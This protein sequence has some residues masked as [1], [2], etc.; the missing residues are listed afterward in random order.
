[1]AGESSSKDISAVEAPDSLD[2]SIQWTAWKACVKN[3]P[4]SVVAVTNTDALGASTTERQLKT[5]DSAK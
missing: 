1:L 5:A 3:G 4:R 2:F